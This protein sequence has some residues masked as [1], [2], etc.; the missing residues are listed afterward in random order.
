MAREYVIS[1]YEQKWRNRLSETESGRIVLVLYDI[2]RRRIDPVDGKFGREWKV[3]F[4]F[5]IFDEDNDYL[6]ICDEPYCWVLFRTMLP[7]QVRDF[8]KV[9]PDTLM[10]LYKNDIDKV[11]DI[12]D[13]QPWQ[14]L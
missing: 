13:M 9:I 2:Q 3:E 5:D 8:Y 1:K 6:T 4:K 11:I 14:C 10:G 7:E 12:L